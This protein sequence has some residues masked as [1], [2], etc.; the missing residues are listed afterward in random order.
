MI[1]LKISHK[2]FFAF[3]AILALVVGTVLI[4]R[5]LFI[6]NFKNYIHQAEYERL[7]E[8][9]PK[10]QEL[11]RI[12]K[13]W[14]SVSSKPQEWRKVLDIGKKVRNL[15]PPP[16]P[17]RDPREAD[18][19]GVVLLDQAKNVL[20]GDR[21]YLD[22]SHLLAVEVDGKTPFLASA[23]TSSLDRN[24]AALVNSIPLLGAW[25]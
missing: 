22:S 17:D 3:L 5:E 14:D 15:L 24:T 10:V 23:S 2:L 12:E 25:K 8:L 11:Y 6:R 20:F 9:V 16:P 19:P 13:S 1:R 21:D 7:Q 18:L 4:S